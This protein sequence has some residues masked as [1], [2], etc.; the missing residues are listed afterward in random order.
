MVA[1]GRN[2]APEIPQSRPDVAHLAL[3]KTR[4]LKHMLYD[5]RISSED[6]PSGPGPLPSEMQALNLPAALLVLGC[7][8][9]TLKV[10]GGRLAPSHTRQ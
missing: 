1:P 5:G 10:S 9:R 7:P 3:Q 4:A 8:G 6:C 2:R